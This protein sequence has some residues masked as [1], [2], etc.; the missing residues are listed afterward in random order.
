MALEDFAA[1]NKT[2]TQPAKIEVDPNDTTNFKF[3]NDEAKG[4]ESRATLGTKQAKKDSEVKMYALDTR[5]KYVPMLGSMEFLVTSGAVIEFETGAAL[6]KKIDPDNLTVLERLT[7]QHLAFDLTTDMYDKTVTED[8]GA[9]ILQLL[10]LS[11]AD[12]SAAGR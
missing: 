10:S 4:C 7:S 9:G 8:D 5:G 6:F 3:G 1:V 12:P 11:A 2:K